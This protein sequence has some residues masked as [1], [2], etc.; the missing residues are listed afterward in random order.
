MV[1]V[2]CQDMLSEFI[3]SGLPERK[4]TAVEAHMRGC[5]PCQALCDDLAQIID[6]SGRLPLHTPSSLLWSR[7]EQAVGATETQSWWARMGARRFDV[8]FTGRQA[9]AAA[10]ALVVCSAAGIGVARFGSTAGMPQ[11]SN[12]GAFTHSAVVT[13]DNFSSLRRVS[14]ETA[15][16]LQS[17]VEQHR[18]AWS[19][20]K[21][22]A[23]DRGLAAVDAR[24]DACERAE[25]DDPDDQDRINRTVAAYKNK[26]VFLQKF[27]HDQ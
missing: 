23:Y 22:G 24:I 15:D 2:E 6:T 11:S 20:E 13:A 21:R 25:Q 7:V 27:N 4:R 10:A 5:P 14:K 12:W 18:T 3:D 9:M 8:S 16:E 19:D 1:C 26:V 17:T